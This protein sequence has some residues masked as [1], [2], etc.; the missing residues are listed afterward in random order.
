MSVGVGAGELLAALVA[1]RDEPVAAAVRP[2]RLLAGSSVS[3]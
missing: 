2:G 3:G 1:G